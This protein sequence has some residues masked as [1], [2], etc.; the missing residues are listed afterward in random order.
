MQYDSTSRNGNTRLLATL[1]AVFDFLAKMFPTFCVL[2]LA[3]CVMGQADSSSSSLD[4]QATID[5]PRPLVNDTIWLLQEA[6]HWTSS[7]R[8]TEIGFEP[9]GEMCHFVRTYFVSH[10]SSVFRLDAVRMELYGSVF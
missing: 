1:L 3:V 10:V 6:Q 7:L 5:A 4:F 2:T 9:S 8:Q